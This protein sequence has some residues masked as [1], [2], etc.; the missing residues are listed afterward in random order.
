MKKRPTDEQIFKMN[1]RGWDT[2]AFDKLTIAYI[3]SRQHQLF[4][5]EPTEL[6]RQGLL[7]DATTQNAL[8]QVYD[9]LNVNSRKLFKEKVLKDEYKFAALLD[10]MWDWFC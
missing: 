4:Y 1:S 3:R 10:K 6:F 8:L 2:I 9:A 5:I 7:V